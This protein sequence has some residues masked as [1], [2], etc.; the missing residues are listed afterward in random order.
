M[1]ATLIA[2]ACAGTASANVYDVI[3]PSYMPLCKN[4]C[5]EKTGEFPVLRAQSYRFCADS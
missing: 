2:L 4:G 1:R 3:M 5:S